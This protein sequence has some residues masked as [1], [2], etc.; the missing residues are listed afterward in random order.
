MRVSLFAFFR[1]FN[2]PAQAF[3]THSMKDVV[4]RVPLYNGCSSRFLEVWCR[5]LGNDGMMRQD[6]ETHGELTGTGANGTFSVGGSWHWHRC[7][8]RSGWHGKQGMRDKTTSILAVC[9]C[10]MQHAESQIVSAGCPGDCMYILSRGDAELFKGD[11]MVE[12]TEECHWVS[13]VMLLE[14][15]QVFFPTVEHVWASECHKNAILNYEDQSNDMQRPKPKHDQPKTRTKTKADTDTESDFA[16]T[17]LSSASIP[18]F[19]NFQRPLQLQNVREGLDHTQLMT[20]RQHPV[21]GGG[22]V[23]NGSII[24]SWLQLSWRLDLGQFGPRPFVM[25]RCF[26]AMMSC[27]QNGWVG[28]VEKIIR[29]LAQPHDQNF[30]L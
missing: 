28:P 9:S 21:L 3:E 20:Y 7:G 8:G 5:G 6:D 13:W 16:R 17:V 29:Q 12:K 26:N 25:S 24:C 19:P 18:L 15:L 2:G 14:G 1:E 23:A 4:E 22:L 30:A 27:R 11:E 10:N